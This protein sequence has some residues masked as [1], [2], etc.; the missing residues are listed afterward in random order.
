MTFPIDKKKMSFL[1]SIIIKDFDSTSQFYKYII[2]TMN[3]DMDDL[4]GLIVFK[5]IHNDKKKT[6]VLNG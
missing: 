4:I 1:L 5:V 6:C 3:H 2:V